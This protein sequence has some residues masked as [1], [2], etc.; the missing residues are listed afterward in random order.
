MGYWNGTCLLSNLPILR[1]ERVVLIL[2]IETGLGESLNIPSEHDRFHKPVMLPIRG[3]Y[4][5]Y[6]AVKNVDN[7]EVVAN[8]LR[9]M[10]KRNEIRFDDTDQYGDVT[11]YDDV[12]ASPEVFLRIVE[13][14][15]MYFT[16][17]GERR[18]LRFSLI[19]ENIFDEMM[20]ILSVRQVSGKDST[21]GSV[22]SRMFYDLVNSVHNAPKNGT[23][24]EILRYSL[25]NRSLEVFRERN[26]YSYN[27]A[28]IEE[29]LNGRDMVYTGYMELMFAGKML[30]SLRKL[31]Y[32]CS[33][34]GSL[35]EEMALH[36][37]LAKIVASHVEKHSIDFDDDFREDIFA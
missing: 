28:F 24:E 15:R 12:Y 34:T 10:V 37:D 23:P 3:Q 32:Y 11:S 6:G 30:D 33:G 29:Y 26:Q 16:R 1:D 21:L 31:W 25:A 2:L 36:S 14:G 22:Y 20:T 17:N 18:Y 27:P 8:W 19:H 5:N 13:R 35:S 4:D 7:S 9:L